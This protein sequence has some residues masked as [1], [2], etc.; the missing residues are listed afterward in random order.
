MIQLTTQLC[1]RTGSPDAFRAARQTFDHSGCIRLA[2][3]LE[4]SLRARLLDAV[5]RAEFYD[6]V[7]DGIGVELC[8]VPSPLTTGLEV[9]LNDPSFLGAVEELTGCAPL[10]CFEGRIYRL[11]PGGDHFDS[12]H[13]DVGQDRQVAMS[14]NLGREPVEGGR[15]QLRRAGSSTL[16]AE[17]ENPVPGDA[18]LFRI[19]PAYEHR[20]APVGGTAPRT[21]CAGWFRSAPDFQAV[22]EERLTS[23][24]IAR[25]FRDGV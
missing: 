6:R 21:A 15:L 1:Q 22:F 13:N 8:A 7:H 14:I 11:L 4:P 25:V 9:L 16:L 18:I 19:D 12:W 2:G 17:V 5:D 10:R 24:D 20:V 3:L 23:A